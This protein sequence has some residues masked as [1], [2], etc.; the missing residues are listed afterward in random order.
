MGFSRAVGVVFGSV[1][2]MGFSKVYC[3][4]V[5]FFGGQGVQTSNIFLCLGPCWGGVWK[6]FFPFFIIMCMLLLQERPSLGLA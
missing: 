2:L 1:V 4:V 3:L 5:F 6:L